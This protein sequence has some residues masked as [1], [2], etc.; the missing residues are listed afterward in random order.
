V[1]GADPRPVVAVAEMV[2]PCAAVELSFA[3]NTPLPLVVPLALGLN[4][5]PEPVEAT[6]TEAPLIRLLN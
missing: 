6:V 5:F 3:A 2:L 4:P 1:I